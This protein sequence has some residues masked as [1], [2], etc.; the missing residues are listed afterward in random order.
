MNDPDYEDRV[1]V[2][3]DINARMASMSLDDLLNL[4]RYIEEL[5]EA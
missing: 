5:A 2:M 3:K 1:A 4:K